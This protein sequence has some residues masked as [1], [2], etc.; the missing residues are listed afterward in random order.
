VLVVPIEVEGAEQT[1]LGFETL[2]LAPIDLRLVDTGLLCEAERAW[3]NAYHARVLEVL[4]PT[5][6]DDVRDWLA[7]A[8][9]AI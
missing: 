9:R 2:T 4:T 3:L 5:V 8:T 1:L 6:P 7:E